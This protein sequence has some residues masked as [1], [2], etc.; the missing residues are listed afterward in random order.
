M[1]PGSLY[2]RKRPSRDTVSETTEISVERKME[3]GKKREGGLFVFVSCTEATISFG[4]GT[5]E[6]VG[7]QPAARRLCVCVVMSHH[8]TFEQHVRVTSKYS[9][10]FGCKVM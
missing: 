7:I 8:F 9:A 2:F 5:N 3:E 6:H 4:R 10:L 1:N